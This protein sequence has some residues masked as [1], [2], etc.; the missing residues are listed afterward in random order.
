[1]LKKFTIFMKKSIFDEY[2]NDF[3]R[4]RLEKAL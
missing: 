4:K 2:N 3:A 1:M